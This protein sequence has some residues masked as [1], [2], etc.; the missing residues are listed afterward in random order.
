MQHEAEYAANI[1][2]QA[3]STAAQILQS[4]NEE[5]HQVNMASQALQQTIEVER[6]NAQQVRGALY[7]AAQNAERDRDTLESIRT[8]VETQQQHLNTRAHMLQAHHVDLV[9]KENAVS[10]RESQS[11]AAQVQLNQAASQVTHALESAE[12]AK[13][14]ALKEQEQAI[15]AQQTAAVESAMLS[16]EQIAQL[17]EQWKQQSLA[18]LT[19][20]ANDAAEDRMAKERQQLQEEYRANMER[21]VQINQ[22]L[23]QEQQTLQAQTQLLQEQKRNVERQNAELSATIAKAPEPPPFKA[24]PATPP[25]PSF[26]PWFEAAKAQRQPVP[27]T[28]PAALGGA[29]STPVSSQFEQS[30]I[31]SQASVSSP[32]LVTGACHTVPDH[33]GKPI[34]ENDPIV[35]VD[36]FSIQ[37]AAAAPGV[38]KEMFRDL[39]EPHIKLFVDDYETQQR[40]QAYIPNSKM[41][42]CVWSHLLTCD[43]SKLIKAISQ[44]KAALYASLASVIRTCMTKYVQAVRVDTGQVLA[45]AKDYQPTTNWWGQPEHESQKQQQSSNDTMFSFAGKTIVAPQ[46]PSQRALWLNLAKQAERIEKKQAAKQREHEKKA[47]S[48]AMKETAKKLRELAN[49]GYT[50][51][52]LEKHAQEEV[53]KIQATQTA[54]PTPAGGSPPPGGGGG[55]PTDEGNAPVAQ[56]SS[57]N[58][59]QT[60][61]GLNTA[62]LGA[63]SE[64][65]GHREPSSPSSSSDSDS[66][67]KKKKKKKKKKNDDSDHDSSSG[68]D[69]SPSP[70]SPSSSHD[71]SSSDSGSK[72]KKKK[73]PTTNIQVRELEKCEQPPLCHVSQIQDWFWESC[74]GFATCAARGVKGFTYASDAAKLS[75]EQLGNTPKEWITA[76]WKLSQALEKI[77]KTDSS[78]YAI[79]R[80]KNSELMRDGL[81]LTGRQKIHMILT[82]YQCNPDLAVANAIEDLS[83]I[84]LYG[85]TRDQYNKNVWAWYLNWNNMLAKIP[86]NAMPTVHHKEALFTRELRKAP[87]FD[88]EMTLYDKGK[89]DKQE[90]ATYDYI[91][92][93]VRDRFHRIR[94]TENRDAAAAQIEYA[95]RY[96]LPSAPVTTGEA[97]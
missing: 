43:N 33:V 55:Q 48:K 52:M 53:A 67:K 58:A 92:A 11:V 14:Q 41:L 6:Y 71:G 16:Q 86:Q 20:A 10:E 32:E 24:P 17:Q 70:S 4:A 54:G 12:R 29:V 2:N 78:L 56:G 31:R 34:G 68:D 5:R 95:N 90:W 97:G 84:K 49:K 96:S 59:I 25:V 30:P 21:Q 7:V 22:A 87:M 81:M 26:D 93:Q 88:V 44:P 51:D 18:A 38:Q 36:A 3:N 37:L 1:V 57:A 77:V 27:P 85:N 45:D 61:L 23:Q 28:S 50:Q 69:N 42:S 94:V 35:D 15:L 47:I 80:D 40:F 83:K 91:H 39:L 46:D 79:I 19:K 9:H 74:N 64:Q 13:Q 8:N 66:R 65:H 89:F 73:K 72:R 63:P 60:R 62:L 82:Y 76:E 75:F